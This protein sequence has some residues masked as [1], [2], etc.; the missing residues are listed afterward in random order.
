MALKGHNVAKPNQTLK[1]KKAAIT[2]YPYVMITWVWWPLK[3]LIYYNR[4]TNECV[5]LTGTRETFQ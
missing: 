1:T 4:D 2:K 3:D 5:Q